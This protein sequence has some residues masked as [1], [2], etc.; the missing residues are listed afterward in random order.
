MQAPRSA[1]SK[2]VSLREDPDACPYAGRLTA[3]IVRES[4]KDMSGSFPVRRLVTRTRRPSAALDYG[5]E[6]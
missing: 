4:S 5:P 6:T 3:S 1:I 2:L